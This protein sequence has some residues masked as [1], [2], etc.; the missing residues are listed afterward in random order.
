MDAANP[1]ASTPEE[2][3]GGTANWRTDLYA[4]R[5]A[6]MTHAESIELFKELGAVSTPELKSAKEEM[7]YEGE[8]SQ[9]DYAQS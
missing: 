4:M 2:Y 7:P 3:M 8:F 1:F 6:L 5:G 9:Q